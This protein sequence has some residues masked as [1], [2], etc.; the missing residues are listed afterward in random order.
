MKTGREDKRKDVE[1]RSEKKGE[2]VINIIDER[3]KK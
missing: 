1:G 3:G 2:K